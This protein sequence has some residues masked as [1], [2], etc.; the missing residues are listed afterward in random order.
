MESSNRSVAVFCGSALPENSLIREEVCSLGAVLA[1][2]KLTLVFGGSAEGL[3]GLLADSVLHA[4]G[5]AVGVL[6][7]DSGEIANA[8]PKLSRRIIVDTTAERK[9]HMVEITDAV[10]LLPGG[11]GAFD[12]FFAAWMSRRLG[13]SNNAIGILNVGG[14]YDRLI[15]FLGDCSDVGL[16]KRKVLSSLIVDQSAPLLVNKILASL[17]RP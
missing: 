11:I 14:Y 9:S 12:E 15:E 17:L 1:E 4:G 2:R 8:H 7:L 13:L 10:I 6:P 5:Q 3:M 16:I